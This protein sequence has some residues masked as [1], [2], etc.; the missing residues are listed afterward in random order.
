[1]ILSSALRLFDSRTRAFVNPRQA[2]AQAG[3][4]ILRL[5]ALG[6]AERIGLA[7]KGQIAVRLYHQIAVFPFTCTCCG[8][9]ITS[10]RGV[11]LHW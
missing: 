11:T 4:I 2:A 8:L 10:S 7:V 1:M 6:G 3:L 5:F 9:R